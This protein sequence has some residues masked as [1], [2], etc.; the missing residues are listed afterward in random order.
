MVDSHAVRA[1]AIDIGTNTVNLLIADVRQGELDRIHSDRRAVGLG[2]GAM[3]T[4]RLQPEAMGRAIEA[5]HDYLRQ[6][7]RL[8]VDMVRVTATSAVRSSENRQ[9]FLDLVRKRT[10]LDVEIIPG[11]REAE[12]IFKG[13]RSSGVFDHDR[14]LIMD[15]GGG[16]TEF[17]IADSERLLWKASYPLGVTRLLEHFTF[18][19]PMKRTQYVQ[20]K[21]H[22][23]ETAK[24]LWVA[25]KKYPC[26]HLIGASGSFNTMTTILAKGDERCLDDALSLL[27]LDEAGDWMKRIREMER[28]ERAAIPGMPADRVETMPYAVSGIEWVIASAGVR[29]MHRCA[30]ALKEGVLTELV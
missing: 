22:Y 2:K 24:S 4:G 7:Q 18:S 16:S 9:Q 6:S 11:D 30:Y 17:I 15:I 5:I 20:L 13:V 12:L 14:A 25:L 8:R 23:L 10:G 21:E 26:Q 3:T 19:D 27:P 28:E 1:A 29:K